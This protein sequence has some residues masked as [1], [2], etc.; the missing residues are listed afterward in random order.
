MA[1]ALSAVNWMKKIQVRLAS[2]E[3]ATATT[4][5]QLT[6]LIWKKV[7]KLVA[8][9]ASFASTSSLSASLSP[10][11]KKKKVAKKVAKKKPN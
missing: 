8:G 7:P 6:N 4:V 11:K 1:G 9:S 2:P 10:R 3:M 5:A